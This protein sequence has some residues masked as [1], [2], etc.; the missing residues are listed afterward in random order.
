MQE[1]FSSGALRIVCATNAFGMGIDR[2][3]VETVVHLDIPGSLEA[4][5]QEIGRAGRD[6]RQADGHAALELRRCE[7]ARV[8]HRPRERR[9]RRRARRPA[10]GSRGSR[11]PEGARSPEA[12]PDGLLRRHVQLSSSDDPSLLRRRGGQRAAAARA[13]T[14]SD[15]SRSATR[16]ACSCARFCLASRE[17]V[18]ATAG[19]RSRRCWLASSRTCP[20]R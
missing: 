9:G 13:A 6:G 1:R 19:G 15:Y 2:P 7:D 3:D 11:A 10:T 20:S 14:A 16:I 18:S 4:Y 12:S 5:Y 8:P 17:R